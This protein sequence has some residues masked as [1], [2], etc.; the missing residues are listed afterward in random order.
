M[1]FPHVW[2]WKVFRAEVYWSFKQ[3]CA[4]WL[5]LLQLSQFNWS[6]YTCGQGQVII[7]SVILK[8]F[9]SQQQRKPTLLSPFLLLW[10][11]ETQQKYHLITGCPLERDASCETYKI[12]TFVRIQRVLFAAYSIV[13]TS[14][15]IYTSYWYPRPVI[16][17]PWPQTC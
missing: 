14:V 10:H 2:Q 5:I 17:H 8:C 9:H 4:K 16:Q 13:S 3:R 6:L 15:G 1:C 11:N 7:S 12:Q